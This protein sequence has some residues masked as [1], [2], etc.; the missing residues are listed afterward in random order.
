MEISTEVAELLREGLSNAEVSRRTGVH[1][2]KVSGAREALQLPS[3]YAML[4]VYVAPDS[5]REHGDRAKYTIE[6]CRCKLCRLANREFENQRTRLLAY[7]RWEP[8]VDAQPVYAHIC[9]L[10]ACGMGLRAISAASKVDRKRLQAILNG[11]PERGTGP[12]EKVRPTLAAAVLAVEPTLDNLSAHANIN[13]TGTTRRLQ[14][15]VAVGW[16]QQHLADELGWTP[17]NLSARIV[18]DTVTVKTART[19]RDVYDRVWNVDPLSHG[20]SYGGITRAKNRAA[21]ARWAPVG[22]WDDD[23]IDDP[24]AFPDWTGRC[25]TAEG[26]RDHTHLHIP[27]CDPC[28]QA[29]AVRRAERHA[30]AQARQLRAHSA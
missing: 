2:V 14:A 25:G 30:R 23:T 19:V 12:Q 28:R 9:Y 16:P 6:K 5:H 10:Q 8:W 21:E 24:A 4:P 13:A 17:T 27:I 7:G 3:H 15:L 22:A 20:A 18:A 1:P 26:Y 29:G 11:R